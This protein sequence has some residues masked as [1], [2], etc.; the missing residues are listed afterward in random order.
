MGD[1]ATNTCLHTMDETVKQLQ[2]AI[3]SHGMTFESIN[4]TLQTNYLPN[5]YPLDPESE[6]PKPP[7]ERRT[8]SNPSFLPRHQYKISSI[9]TFLHPPILNRWT[10][11]NSH[12]HLL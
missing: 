9:N 11:H 8:N 6:H 7:K 12:N 10:H 5:F 4:S 1:G 3:D 2:E